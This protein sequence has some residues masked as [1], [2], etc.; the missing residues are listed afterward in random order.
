MAR[1]EH[2]SNSAAELKKVINKNKNHVTESSVTTTTPM[3]RKRGRPRIDKSS[4]EYL[5]NLAARKQ[6]R[7]MG[8]SAQ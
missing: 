7:E 3:K 2:R 8:T 5:A 4:P 6:A 1:T